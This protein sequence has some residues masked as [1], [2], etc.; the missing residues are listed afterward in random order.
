M[1]SSAFAIADST[2]CAVA[3]YSAPESLGFGASSWGSHG[4]PLDVQAAATGTGVI[5]ER[6]TAPT[7][8]T[9][10]MT[11]QTTSVA[12]AL[13]SNT[14]LGA[15][16]VDLPFFGW[17]AISWT[18]PS[19]N[20]TGQFEMIA[21]GAVA[22]S[23][24]ADGPYF[25][26]GVPAASSLGRFLFT[27][28]SPL[29]MPATDTNGLYAAD[30]CSTPAE[31]LGAGDGCTASSLIAAWGESSGPVTTDSNGDAFAVMSSF[32]TGNQE[33]RG[34]LASSIARGAAATAGVSLFTVPGY[35]GSLAALAPTAT[36]PGL[37]V[38]QAIDATTND[39]LDV[40]QQQFTTGSSLAAV[41]A[42]TKLLTVASGQTEG[43]SFLIDGSQRLW[44]AV[45]GSS[46]TTYVV[47][48]R[49]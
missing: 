30:A 21:N 18:G 31:A 49:Q 42:P 36:D 16:A 6:W 35:S 2:F 13:P 3:I 11:L 28:L 46:S 23:Y 33:A 32:T 47:L 26:A 9:G 45:S 1:F 43:F 8:T 39:P 14:F 24:T 15:Q 17:T 41:G 10:A 34:F 19:A 12:A 38:F 22:T 7:G 37:V 25:A 27:G 29:D 4:G 5:L 40:V 44:V 48:A 20:I